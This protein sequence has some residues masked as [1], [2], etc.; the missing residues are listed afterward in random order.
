MKL[1]KIIIKKKFETKFYWLDCIDAAEG[2]LSW[3]P[4]R[5]GGVGE[6]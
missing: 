4:K 5:G 2:S 1:I 6:P 3:T